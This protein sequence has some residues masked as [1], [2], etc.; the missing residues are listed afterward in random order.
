MFKYLMFGDVRARKYSK[1][2]ARTRSILEKF[3]FDTTL[4]FCTRGAP[5]GNGS[6]NNRPNISFMPMLNES[7]T[8]KNRNPTRGKMH[9]QK[10]TN[11][12]LIQK[13]E[14]SI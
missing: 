1:T 11:T 6:Q 7:Q 4:I 12:F 10:A 8:R 9:C 2:A 3:E 5:T 13:R 14:N